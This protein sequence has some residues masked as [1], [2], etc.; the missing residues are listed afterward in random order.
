[1]VAFISSSTYI[2]FKNFPIQNSSWTPYESNFPYKN[3][4]LDTFG[5]PLVVVNYSHLRVNERK[6]IF[7]LCCVRRW[8]KV[9]YFVAPPSISG[10]FWDLFLPN[11]GN[12]ASESLLRQL[13]RVN[14]NRLQVISSHRIIDLLSLRATVTV[15]PRLGVSAIIAY[16]SSTMIIKFKLLDQ[17]YYY[18][19][20][21]GHG[22]TGK[23]FTSSWATGRC[24]VLISW[25]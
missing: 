16:D 23:Y 8:W 20:G 6:A 4:H 14:R 17:H 25:N 21:H 7:I 12:H 24:F 11:T 18:G 1:M 3:F 19:H 5:T 2:F 9:P 10:I 13:E 22:H 15:T